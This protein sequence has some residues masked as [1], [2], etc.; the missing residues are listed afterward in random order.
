MPFRSVA[1]AQAI[2]HRLLAL[3][4]QGKPLRIVIAGAGISGVEALGEMLR[5]HRDDA[6]LSV[7]VVEAGERLLT[8]LPPALDMDIRRLCEPYAVKF[9]TA[10]VIAGVT[11]KGVRLAVGTRLRSELTLWTAGLAP[12]TLLRESG[13]SQRDQVWADVHATFQSRYADNTFVIGDAA[14]L[15]HPVG[16]QAFR[17]I[18]MGALAAAN[19]QRF[20]AGRALTPFKPAPKPMLIAFGDLQTYMVAGRKVIASNLIACAKGRLSGVHGADCT[21]GFADIGAGC[22]R[23][24][25]AE[26]ARAGAASARVAGGLQ[27]AARLPVDQ[28]ALVGPAARIPECGTQCSGTW[29]AFNGHLLGLDRGAAMG[30]DGDGIEE[31][32]AARVPVLQRPP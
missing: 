7:D 5:R 9:H 18:D 12:P 4:R 8:G 21:G 13:L 16:K 30:T 25:V 1:D 10:S 22:R 28:A 26:L 17:A 15:P 19:V 27:E 29:P 23:S 3:V 31:V 20:L 32:P 11:A 6:S 2:E 14:Q 24:A